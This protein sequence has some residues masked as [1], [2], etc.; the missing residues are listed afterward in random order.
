VLAGEDTVR[1][2][3]VVWATGY[4]HDWSW[5]DPA[6][7]DEDGLPRHAAGVGA[8]EGSYFVGLHRLRSRGSALIG[9]VG[10]DAERLMAHLTASADPLAVAA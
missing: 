6:L 4:R 3:A 7:L 2:D 10:R 8:V 9:F 1:P 5:L